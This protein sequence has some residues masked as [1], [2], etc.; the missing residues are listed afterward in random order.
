MTTVLDPVIAHHQ[1]LLTDL[2]S[3]A[4]AVHE[5][6]RDGRDVGDPIA[7]LVRFVRA[8]LLPHAQA[9]EETLYAAAVPIM[10]L[11]RFIDG[12]L[13][14]HQQLGDLCHDLAEV[15]DGLVAAETAHAMLAV[16]AGHVRRENE[17]LLPALAE[18]PG[19]DL[20]GLI[21][22]MHDAFTRERAGA[23]A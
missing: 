12:M 17:I 21:A 2:T 5:A 18:L 16:F 6:A 7:G 1:Q 10:A 23:P 9:E 22:D 14:E 13:F 11:G 20:G 3:L 19:V 8:E 4:T 15:S